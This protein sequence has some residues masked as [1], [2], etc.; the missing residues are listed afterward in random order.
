[1]ESDAL[2]VA[3]ARY[4]AAYD[5]YQ[6]CVRNV[7]QKL[8]SGADLPAEEILEEAKA[9]ERLA[10]A[11]RELLDAIAKAAARSG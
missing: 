11:R 4:E 8:N 3:R 7:R 1:M 6:E 10:T 9:T 2:S 5:A